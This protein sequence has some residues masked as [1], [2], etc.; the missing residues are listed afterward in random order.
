MP[1]S[2]IKRHSTGESEFSKDIWSD[3]RDEE[4]TQC[5]D[6]SFGRVSLCSAST[7]EIQGLGWRECVANFIKRSLGMLAVTSEIEGLG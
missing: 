1:V 4:Q 3:G 2:Q 6:G 7:S 5:Q